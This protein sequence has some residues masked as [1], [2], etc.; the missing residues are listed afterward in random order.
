MLTTA[1]RVMRPA[2]IA[3]NIA[4]NSDASSIPSPLN[5]GIANFH[6]HFEV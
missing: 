1:E 4:Q 6:S 2:H 5:I 3:D